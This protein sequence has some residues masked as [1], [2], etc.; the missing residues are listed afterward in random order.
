VQHH[1]AHIASAMAENDISIS[2]Q[3]VLGI[4][5]DGLG[6]G[7]DQTLWGGEFLL[8]DYF[9]C[10]R[11]ARF[12][13][14]AMPGAVQ[15][16]KQPWR[17]T[18]AHILNS[19]SWNDF[20]KDYSKTEIAQ[21]LKDLPIDTIQTMLK[22]QINCPL[23]S[24]TGRLFDA[25]AGAVGLSALQVQYEGQAA[26][27]LEMLADSEAVLSES[28]T[29]PYQFSVAVEDSK[30][31]IEINAGSIWPDLLRDIKFGETKSVIATRFHAGLIDALLNVVDLLAKKYSFQD[32]VLSGGCMQN[33]ILLQGLNKR[34]VERQF[35][36][37]THSQVP[38]NDGGI[39]L[40][41]VV[42][43]AARK[44]KNNYLST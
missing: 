43:A 24:S 3:A 33:A 7:N 34:L 19:M 15:A 10:Q 37:L 14:I 23:A 41:Q 20:M 5:L 28:V 36:C 22:K 2:H 16:I 12:K 29:N 13:P 25:V 4:A 18:V 35:N 27:E 32:V 39:A 11:L 17:N 44:I 26:M 42:I 9:D 6:Y 1:H 30:E 40:G 21:L 8:T 31:L 38:A